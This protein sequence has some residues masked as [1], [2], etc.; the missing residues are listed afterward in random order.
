MGGVGGRRRKGSLAVHLGFI[1]YNARVEPPTGFSRP[2]P[3]NHPIREPPT[4]SLNFV[5]VDSSDRYG[6]YGIHSLMA[7]LRAFRQFFF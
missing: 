6:Y 3:S 2:T 1:E 5:L 4:T 7:F